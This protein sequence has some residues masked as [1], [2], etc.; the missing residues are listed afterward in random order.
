[1]DKVIYDEKTG[2]SYSLGDDGMYYPNLTIVENDDEDYNIGKYGLL[3][4]VYL[5]EHRIGTY[6]RLLMT[7]KLNK[8]LYEIDLLAQERV[9]EIVVSMAKDD[10]TDENLKA[11][12]QMKWVCRMNNYRRCAEEIVFKDF[13]YS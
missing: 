10:G 8:H 3:R 7:G 11:T 1:M 13:L 6:N 12:D 5:K 4:G 9:D 2:L